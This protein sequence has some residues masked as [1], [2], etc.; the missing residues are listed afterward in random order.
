MMGDIG[1]RTLLKSAAATAAVAAAPSALGNAI[2]SPEQGCIALV[3]ATI[4]PVSSDKVIK[5][6]VVCITGQH[7]TA[8]GEKGRITIPPGHKIVDVSGKWITPGLIDSNAHM[9]LTTIPE[10]FVKYEDRLDEVAL[11]SAQVSLKYG[12]TT[13]GDSWG[14]VAPLLRVR[15][16]IKKGEVVGTRLLVAGNIVGLG[17][18]FSPY[19]MEGWDTRGVATRYGGWV[20]QDVQKRI[21]AQWEA[22]VG[23]NL[24][25][26]TPSEAAAALR[27]YIGRG[28]DFIKLAISAHGIS[29]VEPMMFSPEA[30]AAMRKE[31]ARANIP[32]QTHTFTLDSLLAGINL[33]PDLMQ[34]PNVGAF[35]YSKATADQK[36]ML[37]IAIARTRDEGIYAGLMMIPN[38]KI[39]ETIRNWR[40]EDHPGENAMNALVLERQMAPADLYDLQASNVVPWIKAK[41]PF[42]IATDSGPEAPEFGPLAWGKIGRAHFERMEA[43]QQLGA[44]PMDVLRAATINGARAYRIGDI[45]GSIET[46]KM[47]DMIVIDGDPLVDVAN[48]R[49]IN[50]IMKEGSI[51][52]R[53]ALPNPS[54]LGDDPESPWPY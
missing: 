8:V 22:G 1:R 27:D 39:F 48:L 45:T 47:A 29:P 10:F 25:A 52:D 14:P 28:V 11:E 16:R 12:L 38:K 46:G 26:L 41:V 51:I 7:I 30:L 15:D 17:G 53:D 43:L 37:D 54:I 2:A 50:M 24:L 32:F 35:T 31:V 40:T 20:H 33:K 36:R 6:G 34:H 44:A 13:S 19:F 5:N 18:P 49:R 9:V 23:P 3:G 21:N 42:T 4:I